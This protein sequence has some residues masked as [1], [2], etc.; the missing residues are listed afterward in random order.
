MEVTCWRHG[1]GTHDVCKDQDTLKMLNVQKT[2]IELFE[3]FFTFFLLVSIL[4]DIHSF[5]ILTD[6]YSQFKFELHVDGILF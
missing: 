3:F 2:W 6:Y 4:V 1:D 5:S